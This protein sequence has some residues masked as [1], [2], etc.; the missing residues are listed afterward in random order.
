MSQTYDIIFMDI[1]MPL[2]DGLEACREIRTRWPADKQPHIVA[3]TAYAMDGDRET[4]LE[5]G[6]NDY[7]SKPLRNTELEAVLKKYS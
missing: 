7:I 3:I 2:M 5:S 4:C 6:M 1:R